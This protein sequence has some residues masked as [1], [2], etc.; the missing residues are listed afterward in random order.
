MK[1]FACDNCLQ[2]LFF[3]KPCNWPVTGGGE[4]K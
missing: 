2:T 3:E 1:L 4:P